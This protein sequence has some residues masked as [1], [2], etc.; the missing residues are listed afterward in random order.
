MHDEGKLPLIRYQI[1]FIESKHK[2]HGLYIAA[3]NSIAKIAVAI[4]VHGRVILR[5]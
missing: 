5:V 4:N 1:F 2:V 3:Q